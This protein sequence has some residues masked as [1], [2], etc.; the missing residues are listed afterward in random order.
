[1]GV[2]GRRWLGQSLL[3]LALWLFGAASAGAS[4]EHKVPDL[5]QERPQK[6]ERAN[7][8]LRIP[9]T[10]H[11]ATVVDHPAYDM[12][13]LERAVRRANISLR[14]YGIEV[15]VARIEMMPEGFAGI[16]HRRD[17]RRL[18][19]FAEH[20]GTVHVFLVR[21]VE[22]GSV[23][24]ADR[25]VRGLHWRYRGVLRKLRSREFLVLGSDAPATTLVHEL[26]HLF[27]LEHDA[28]RQ[29]LMCS[30]REGPR[31]IF[32]ATQGETIRRGAI[33]YLQRARG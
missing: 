16:R 13:R 7:I 28:G 29:N 25:G 23:L 30:C 20:D 24:R 32:T 31:Q 19:N 27:G 9:M 4:G 15:Y 33:Q 10:L 18:A 6:G 2:G 1:M 8:W 12:R 26:G 3:T 5:R 11:M 14:S 22:L 17:R 21:T